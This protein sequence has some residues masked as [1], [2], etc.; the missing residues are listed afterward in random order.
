[1]SFH[2]SYLWKFHIKMT[3]IFYDTMEKAQATLVQTRETED[4]TVVCA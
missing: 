1:M 2:G 3:Q 4:N